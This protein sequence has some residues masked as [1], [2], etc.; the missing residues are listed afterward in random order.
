MLSDPPEQATIDALN[1]FLERLD[2]GRVIDLAAHTGL[3]ADVSPAA[4][5]TRL[6]AAFDVVPT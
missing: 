3:P 6:T 2:Q 4:F 1:V 5:L